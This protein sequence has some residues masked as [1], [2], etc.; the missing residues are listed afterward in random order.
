LAPAPYQSGRDYPQQFRG[1]H[2]DEAPPHQPPA[3]GYRPR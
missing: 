1:G 2:Y 3:G